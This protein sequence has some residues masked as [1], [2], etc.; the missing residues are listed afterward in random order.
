[1]KHQEHPHYPLDSARNT[2]V[3]KSEQTPEEDSYYS[4]EYTF[5]CAICHSL[6]IQREF[7]IKKNQLKLFSDFYLTLS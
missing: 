4:L 2:V 3:I 7:R 1:M 5:E 6:Y